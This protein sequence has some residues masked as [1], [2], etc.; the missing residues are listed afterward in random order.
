MHP[1]PFHSTRR[2]TLPFISFAL[3]SSSRSRPRST[4][5]TKE[6]GARAEKPWNEESSGPP[7][8]SVRQGIYL[9]VH[10]SRSSPRSR[11]CAPHSVDPPARRQSVPSP[12]A[13]LGGERVL[14]H[15]FL[16]ALSSFPPI[17]L[18]SPASHRLVVSPP[19]LPTSCEHSF[20]ILM[21][22]SISPPTC[23]AAAAGWNLAYA[24]D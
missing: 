18:S 12:R 1:T 3:T 9:P 10:P 13:R 5:M 2:L 8:W 14:T 15:V 16:L 4:R 6:S 19:S 24:D 11:V 7:S 17:S 20:C 22:Y 23:S 21:L